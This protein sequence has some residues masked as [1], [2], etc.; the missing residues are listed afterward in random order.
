MFYEILNYATLLAYTAFSID[1]LSQIIQIY[2]RKSSLD[3]SIRGILVRLLGSFILAIK[4]LTTKDIYLIYGQFILVSIIGIY[5]GFLI[6]YRK[7]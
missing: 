4:M 1:L 7:K 3:V 6:Y 2:I 5:L